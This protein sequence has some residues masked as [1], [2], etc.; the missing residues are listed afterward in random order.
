MEYDRWQVRYHGAV[1][2][3]NFP[4]GTRPVD[5]V[6]PELG[7]VSKAMAWENREVWERLE[8]QAANEAYML[9][10]HRQLPERVI[11][12]GAEGSEVIVLSFNDGVEGGEDGGVE[13]IE[14]GGED[15]EIDV[16]EWSSVFSNDPDD[17]R[18]QARGTLYLTR[19]HW[20]DLHLDRN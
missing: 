10:L 18:T 12:V 9:E 4:F 3:L 14:V 13:G 5:L 20:L 16:D 2:R 19:K 1:A 11:F 17:G 7:V 15:K 6:T 8:A